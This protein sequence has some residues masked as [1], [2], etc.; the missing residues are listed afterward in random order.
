MIFQADLQMR[1]YY[2]RD[3]YL[4]LCYRTGSAIGT[5]VGLKWNRFYF[6]YVFDYNLTPLQQ[7]TFGSHEVNLAYKIGDSAR[8]YRW[9][10]RY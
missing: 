2:N 5:M 4:G 7:H 3:Y 6:S 8:R 10:I 9:L 1:I